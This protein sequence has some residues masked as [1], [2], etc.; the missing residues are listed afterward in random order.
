MVGRAEK[1]IRKTVYVQKLSFQ[2][3]QELSGVQ[4]KTVR[5]RET[6]VADRDG[7]DKRRGSLTYPDKI[8]N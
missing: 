3:F 7:V 4:K 8:L 2:E 6:L 1:N 5:S